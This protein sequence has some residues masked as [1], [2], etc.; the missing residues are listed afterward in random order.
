MNYEEA[1]QFLESFPNLD[2]KRL[3]QDAGT[4]FMTVEKMRSILTKMNNPQLGR[5]TVHVTGSKGKGSTATFIA[6]ALNEADGPT[7]LFL[8]PHLIS[9]T[10]RI[11]LNS[12]RIK[13][14]EFAKGLSE[15]QDA[16]LKEHN[17]SD[18][19]AM[20]HVLIALFF[21]LSSQAKTNW[22]VLEVGLG[23]KNDATS[24]FDQKEAAVFSPIHIEHREFLGDTIESITTNK[25]GIITQNTNVV[26]ASQEN[27]L[28]VATLREKAKEN[29][30]AFVY[31]PYE[32]RLLDSKIEN[33]SQSFSIEGPFGIER[34][35]SSMLGIH[36]AINI[37]T[38][39]A[40]LDQ[41]GIKHESARFNKGFSKIALPGRFEI[42][43][44]NPLVI[45]DGAHTPE[46][47][48]AVWESVKRSFRFEK[49]IV[50]LS[51]NKDK[52]VEELSERLLKHAD[53]AIVTE[54]QAKNAMDAR[55]L[56]E[57]VSKN[58]SV[59]TIISPSIK[60]SIEKAL[61]V[62]GKNDLILVCGSLYAASE[63]RALYNE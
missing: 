40:T 20:F 31:V 5:K 55:R 47:A 56:K 50:I 25:S 35:Q 62:A 51:V 27:D 22:Q 52:L 49:S 39:L 10:E 1:I 32:Y 57:A 15:I 11:Y 29:N 6:S 19:V 37:M 38:A 7:S 48:S 16:L 30:A 13:E 24:V 34:F 12:E 59:E 28:V 9:H 14:E 44:Q 58:S 41:L 3:Y 18:P 4:D 33:G 61:S 54:S 17:E 53:L 8:C 36:Q 42:F 43:S 63:V 23:G 21:H 26:V 60:L 45:A 46:S 2:Q